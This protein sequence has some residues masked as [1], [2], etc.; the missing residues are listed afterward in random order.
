MIFEE[1]LAICMFG[2]PFFL[3]V[4][5]MPFWTFYEVIIRRAKRTL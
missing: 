5:V 1:F 2:F 4:C 3:I